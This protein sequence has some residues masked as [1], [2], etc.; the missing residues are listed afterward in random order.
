MMRSAP[1]WAVLAWRTG[2]WVGN[3]AAWTAPTAVI[4]STAAA[5]T[6]MRRFCFLITSKFLFWGMDRTN[7]AAFIP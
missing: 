2:S 4:D 1:G 3:P 5:S 7:T 6:L